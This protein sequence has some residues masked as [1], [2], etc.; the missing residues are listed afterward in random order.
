MPRL[1]SAAR[2]S[3]WG[4]ADQAFSSLT[5]FALGV[6]VA[7]STDPAGFGA[8]GLAFATYLVAMNVSR[9]LAAEPLMVRY[10]G[11][12]ADQW[13]AATRRALGVA[14]VT[15]AG[16]GLLCLLASL[17][18]H[19]PLRAVM[20]ALGVAL[21]GLLV[22][23][24][25]RFAFFAAKRGRSAFVNDLVWALVQFPA[26]AL[27]IWS[28]HG[29]VSALTLA[30]GGAATLAGLYGIAQARALPRPLA[31]S[32]W[33][34]EHRSLAYRFL[35]ELMAL[36]GTAQL[37]LFGIGAIA[38]LQ[39]VGSI[40][41]AQMLLGPAYVLSIGMRL[42]AIPHAIEVRR[43]SPERLLATCLTMSV[44]LAGATAAWGLALF[45]IPG[46][47]GSRILGSSWEGAHAVLVAVTLAM[48][49]SA[50]SLG[51]STGL[52]A[53][54][55]AKRSLRARFAASAAYLAL[56]IGGAAVGASAAAWGLAAGS[57]CTAGAFWLMLRASVEAAGAGGPGPPVPAGISQPEPAL[58]DPSGPLSPVPVLSDTDERPD[59]RVGIGGVT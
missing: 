39:A 58:D 51:A 36:S 27:V 22:Q 8:F 31:T 55:D 34:R 37:V 28:G 25:W 20:A 50:V 43:R 14:A 56:G 32:E 6:V 41:G 45:A 23:D 53:M 10:S 47:V 29:S 33:L 46:D 9:A 4:I 59:T 57:V 30:W 18:L 13:R 17:T 49:F 7:R 42:V 26:L 16:L 54:A 1:K 35:A 48:A 52:R 19:G 38:G 15:G 3:G 24:A 2:R 11:V 12:P 21:P 5:N 40:R 44:G